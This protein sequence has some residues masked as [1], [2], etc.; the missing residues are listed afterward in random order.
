LD[1]K[2]KNIILL[3]INNL[4]QY[5]HSPSK[6][7]IYQTTFNRIIQSTMKKSILTLITMTILFVGCSKKNEVKPES[8]F[9][10]SWTGTYSGGDKGSI[11][12]DIDASGNLK[13]ASVSSMTLESF[14]ITGTVDANGAFT[15]KTE[16]GTTFTGNFTTSAV[17]GTWTNTGLKLSGAWSGSKK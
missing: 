5:Y 12:V 13:G 16:I 9:K 15:G 8:K 7:N 4:T 14:G 1:F 2:Q 10:G 6:L 11:A 3:H 17:A